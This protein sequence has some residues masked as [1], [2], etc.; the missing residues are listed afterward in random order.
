MIA[1]AIC[2]PPMCFLCAAK[3]A[4]ARICLTNFMVFVCVWLLLESVCN[5]VGKRM[6]FGLFKV[7]SCS[8]C[9]SYVLLENQ[10]TLLE[11]V[12]SSMFFDKEKGVF[13]DRKRRRRQHICKKY[14]T[15]IQIFDLSISSLSQNIAG[16]L[17]YRKYIWRYT[18][19]AATGHYRERKVLFVFIFLFFFFYQAVPQAW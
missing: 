11:N 1:G 16:E 13:I 2:Q 15:T 19:S 5:V 8:W 14:K 3:N 7:Y 4:T 17:L 9:L 18:D 6:D 12:V 10:T